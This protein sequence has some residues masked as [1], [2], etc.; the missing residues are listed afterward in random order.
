MPLPEHPDI[1][2]EKTADRSSL[3]SALVGDIITWTF[4]IEN[5]GDVT[6]ENIVLTDYLDGIEVDD[7]ELSD[8]V[9]A[10]GDATTL[11]GTYAITDEDI[12]AGSVTNVAEI[13]GVSVASGEQVDDDAD[14]TVL[15]TRAA[16]L[17]DDL[18]LPQTGVAS[19]LIAIATAFV[20][21]GSGVAINFVMYPTDKSGGFC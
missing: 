12:T 7:A 20:A 16:S 6:L 3:D 10:P 17:A 1:S 13:T 4:V 15:L 14:S 9:L 18:I 19:L 21:A 5:T 8:V 2:L 11:Y